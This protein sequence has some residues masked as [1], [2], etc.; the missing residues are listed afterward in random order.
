MNEL[1]KSIDYYHL[2]VGLWPLCGCGHSL[3]NVGEVNS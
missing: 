1:V 2:C 3:W